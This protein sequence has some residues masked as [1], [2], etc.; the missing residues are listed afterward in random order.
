MKLL[1][2]LVAVIVVL[3]GVFAVIAV[4]AIV[5]AFPTMLILGA[6]SSSNGLEFV[7]AL[8]FWQTLGSLF[9]IGSIGRSFN[10][11]VTTTK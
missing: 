2:G 5:A 7:P 3:V 9:V 1:E 6:L 11:A 4:G 10:A 8:G